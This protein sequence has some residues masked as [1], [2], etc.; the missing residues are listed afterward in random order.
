M[1]Q[2]TAFAFAFLMMA[3]WGL[4]AGDDPS[5]D[6]FAGWNW[7]PF[8][9]Y[10]DPY[11]FGGYPYGWPWAGAGVIVP[12]NGSNRG[13][14][15]LPCGYYGYEPFWGYGYGVRLN[16]KGTREHPE[17]SKVPFPPQPG[18]APLEPHDP[19][20]EKQ[21]DRDIETFLGELSQRWREQLQT[22][23]AVQ[24]NIPMR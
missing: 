16:L 7:S 19:P 1:K 2:R 17:L 13:T 5:V 9:Y 12:L 21:W 6:L 11:R 10:D 22:N 4:C 18:A 14:P 8:P 24:I 15:Y 20:H 23:S 3:A